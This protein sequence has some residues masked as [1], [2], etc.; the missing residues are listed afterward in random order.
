MTL[1]F[2]EHKTRNWREHYDQQHDILTNLNFFQHWTALQFLRWFVLCRWLLLQLLILTPIW[3]LQHCY[4]LILLFVIFVIIHQL[5]YR[6]SDVRFSKFCENF[7]AL[8]AL[9]IVV[10]WT[11]ACTQSQ[12]NS[13][14]PSK[15][16][17]NTITHWFHRRI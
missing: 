3:C 5:F 6:Y 12:Q 14:S 9:V 8:A 2:L 4:W 10:K 13:C 1:N 11:L 17:T 15:M 16:F 7:Q